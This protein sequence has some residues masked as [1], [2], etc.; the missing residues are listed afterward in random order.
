MLYR[1]GHGAYSGA[2]RLVVAKTK[3]AAIRELR[4]RGVKRDAARKAINDLASHQ[5]KFG[6][7]G[8]CISAERHS[9]PIEIQVAT[10]YDNETNTYK[11][12]THI[13]K[14]GCLAV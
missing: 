2:N 10:I 4:N 6:Y 7:S 14:Y 9:A 5:M 1:I 12:A 8:D 11:L 3:A 13:D